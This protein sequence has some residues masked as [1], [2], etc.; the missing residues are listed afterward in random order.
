MKFKEFMIAIFA[1]GFVVFGIICIGI[2]VATCIHAFSNPE[3]TATQNI[4]WV[5]ESKFRTISV[6]GAIM[7]YFGIMS[8]GKM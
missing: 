6:I 8:F 7:S 4:L 1:L 5:F 3:L 2:A